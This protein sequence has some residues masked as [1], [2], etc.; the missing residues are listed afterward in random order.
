M[1]YIARFVTCAGLVMAATLLIAATTA[2][3]AMAPPPAPAV[4]I[5]GATIASGDSAVLQIHIDPTGAPFV[6]FDF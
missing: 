2:Q 1:K 3:A 5:D 6:G 4:W